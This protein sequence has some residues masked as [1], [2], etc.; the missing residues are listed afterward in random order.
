MARSQFPPHGEFESLYL[1]LVKLFYEKDDRRQTQ[2]IASRL[3]KSARGFAGLF[4]FDPWRRDPLL[5]RRVPRGFCRGG[6]SRE[7]EIRKI[8]EL[9]TLTANTENWK[10]VARQYDF[11]DVSDRL[12]LLAILYDTQGELDRAIST[13]LE[14]KHYCQSHRIPFDA[15]DLLEELGQAALGQPTHPILIQFPTNWSARSRED[16]PRNRKDCRL[17]YSPV[18]HPITST[19]AASKTSTA[20]P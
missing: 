2:K 13:L 20:S 11:S 10:Y 4:R 18:I 8:L 14:S 5:D 19:G 12:D 9:H 1:S 6:R 16:Q 17:G 3:E 15:Q 7:A